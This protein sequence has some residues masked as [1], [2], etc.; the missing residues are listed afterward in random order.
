MAEQADVFVKNNLTDTVVVQRK[1]ANGT[2]DLTENVAPGTV[3]P[4][5]PLIGLD[6]FIIINAPAGVD[7]KTCPFKVRA[8]VD[9]TVACSRTDSYWKL[10]IVPN[11]LPPDAPTT[12]NVSVGDD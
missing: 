4:R 8:D 12:V 2:I 7:T 11:S 3:S 5:I 6:V 1:L 9:V 10:Q